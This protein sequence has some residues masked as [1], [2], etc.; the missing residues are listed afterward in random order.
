MAME[1]PHKMIAIEDSLNS[2]GLTK[3]NQDALAL[4]HKNIGLTYLKVKKII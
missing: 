1:T 3:K 4:A 2:L